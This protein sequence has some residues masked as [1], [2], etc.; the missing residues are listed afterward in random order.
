VWS[1]SLVLVASLDRNLHAVQPGRRPRVVWERNQKNGLATSPFVLDSRLI[2][3]ESGTE[4]RLV[5]IDLRSRE[6]TWSLELGDLVASPLSADERIYVVTGT[7][8][9][10]AVSHAGAEVWRAELETR[11]A[12][13]PVRV[14]SA[15]LVAA[16]DG[17]LF[18]LDPVSGV[19]RERIDPGAGPIWGDPALLDADHAVYATL[20]GQVFA[21]TAD[22]EVVARR[23]F[24]SRFFAGPVL[25]EGILLLAGHEGTIW[26]Y[27]WQSAEIRWRRDL[28][29]AIR[30]APAVG[31]HAVAIGD[32]GGT[33]YQ[34]DRATGELLWHVRLDGAITASPVA[35]GAELVVATEQGTLY[36]FRP[37]SPASR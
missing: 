29:G 19:V 23:S 11:I 21:V 28:S 10:V 26:A 8:L 22:L 14:G 5:A 20:E 36:A 24:P 31:P 13:R 33:L 3:A 35:R 27:G 30:A 12:A 6:E 17:T 18:A 2:L 7:G 9:V 15:L 32:L 16:A 34:L 37:T 4:G 25:D 1:D